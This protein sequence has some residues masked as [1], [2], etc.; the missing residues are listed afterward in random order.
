M[1]YIPIAP[2]INKRTF[3]PLPYFSYQMGQPFMSTFALVIFG[4]NLCNIEI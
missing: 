2:G 1:S 3:C 4:I